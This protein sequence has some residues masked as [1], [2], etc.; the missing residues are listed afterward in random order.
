MAK[1]RIIIDQEVCIGCKTCTSI[2]PEYFGFDE[3]KGKAKPKK[4]E[5]DELGCSQ[6]ASDACPVLAITVEKIK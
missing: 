4:S 1:Y 6:K 3:R 2:C 5:I